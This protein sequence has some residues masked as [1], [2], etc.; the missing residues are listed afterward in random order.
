MGEII[1]A[2]FSEILPGEDGFYPSKIQDVI[3]YIREGNRVLPI[4]VKELD[5]QYINLDGRHRLISQKMVGFKSI[6]LFIADSCE[7][8]LLASN[9]PEVNSWFLDNNNYN[10]RD[11]WDLVGV[12]S[13]RPD[14][15][16]FEEHFENLVRNFPFMKDIHSFEQAC[17]DYPL[18]ETQ[19][20]PSVANPS[21]MYFLDDD[22]YWKFLDNDPSWK[23]L[24]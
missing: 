1:E 23:C 10:L 7:D 5:G 18:F 9:F 22:P 2:R 6:E 19:Y 14:V 11:R 8:Y 24:L 4:P 21:G 16:S 13:Y 3:N 20:Y 12:S 15:E 17:L